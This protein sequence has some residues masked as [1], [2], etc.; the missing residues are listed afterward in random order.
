MIIQSLIPGYPD[1]ATHLNKYVCMLTRDDRVFYFLGSDNYYEHRKDDKRSMQFALCT[2]MANKHLRASEIQASVLAIPHRTLMNWMATYRE[3][4]ANG[5]FAIKPHRRKP[6]VMT[7][8]KVAECAALLAQNH[9][10]AEVARL[11]GIGESTLRKAITRKIIPLPPS[12]DTVEGEANQTDTPI[13]ALINTK[14]NP[15]P[16]PQSI[17][18]RTTKGQRSQLDAEAANGIGTACTRADERIA[19]AT[20]L[21]QCASTRFEASADV[22][23]GGLLA[24]LPALCANGLLS[25]IGKHLNLP[26]GFYSCLHIL[27]TLGFMALGRIRRPEGLR[28]HPPGEFGKLIGLDRVPEVRTLREKVSMMAATGTPGAWMQELSKAWMA[29]DPTEAGYLY[30][31]GHV[32]VYHGDQANLSKRYVSRER[33]CLRG[34][35]DYWIN[36]ALG[37]PFFVVSKAVNEGMAAAIIND[38]VP[39]LLT[40]VPQQPSADELATHPQRHRFVL[41]FDREG[42]TN[43]LLS[44]LWAQRIGAITYRKNV[45]D[46]WPDTEFIDT[47]VTMPDGGCTTLKLAMRETRLG[48][49]EKSQAVK[50]VRRLTENG[51]QVA[52]VS[53]ARELDNMTIAGRMFARW[54]QENYFAYMMQHYDIDG[55]LQYGTENIPGTELVINPEWN[56]MD[57]EVTKLRL[58]LRKLQAKLGAETTKNA[59]DGGVVQHN[60]ELLQSVQTAADELE[61]AKAKRKEL[62]RKVSI[63]SLPKAERAT[64]LKPLNKQL[65]DCVKM[66]AYRAET[67]LVGILRRHLKKEDEARALIRELFVASADIV[68]DAYAKTITVKIHRMANPSHDRAIAALLNELNDLG[69]CHPETQDKMIYELI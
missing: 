16:I 15:L 23:M 44:A 40:T 54:C 17:P 2:L 8:E 58:Q 53:T 21:A 41:I 63:D 24:G 42:A 39:E 10:P 36:D 64:Q 3:E 52:I 20:G 61:T 62:K 35:T 50:E 46:R 38:I 29:D 66:I 43:S 47:E 32:R 51:H 18:N 13:D 57:K 19:A 30:I 59:V 45:K 14:E 28:H 12:V 60:A 9:R 22:I 25:G 56:L 65:G 27:I 67:A 55:L 7:A 68:P 5:F 6:P 34:T 26:Q 48:L 31:D 33:L 69:F 4:G 11:T 37:R 49:S 1:G